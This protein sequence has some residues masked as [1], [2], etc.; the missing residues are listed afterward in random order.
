MSAPRSALIRRQLRQFFGISARRVAVRTEIPWYWRALLWGG[1]LSVS[2]VLAGG[3]Y[4]TGRRFAGFDSRTMGRELAGLQDRLAELE[5]ELAQ[6]RSVSRAA[7][8][9][10]QVEKATQDELA[11]QLRT[12]Q[13]ENAALKEELAV[14][15]GFVSG[16][17]AQAVGL[18]IVRV[19]VELV[20]GPAGR[21]RYRVLLVNRSAVRGIQEVRGDLQFELQIGQSGKDA[22]I[23][24]P[25]S[26]HAEAARYRVTVKH[27][28][29][30]EGEFTVPP[31]AVLK[32]G[33]VRLLQDGQ[34]RAR[35]AIVL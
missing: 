28:H 17:A 22:S 2:L 15:E 24:L 13:R 25:G 16:A 4:D 10:L 11:V 7:D 19:S 18:R 33:E 32:G 29:R 35:Q 12:L 31:G 21:Y 3:L 14:F 9:R 27:F 5:G 34:V 1:V 23:K 26:D 20:D 8:S 6:L 30:A